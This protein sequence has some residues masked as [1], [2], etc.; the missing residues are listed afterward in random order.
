M[1]AAQQ[2][3]WPDSTPP[4]RAKKDRFAHTSNTKFGMGDNYGIGIKQKTGTLRRSAMMNDLPRSKLNK[5][6]KSLA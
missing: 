5:P 4:K 2:A 1:A 3:N 6:P